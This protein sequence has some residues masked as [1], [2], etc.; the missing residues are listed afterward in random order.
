MF[1]EA[2]TK[3]EFPPNTPGHNW[4][5]DGVADYCFAGAGLV[6]TAG[7]GVAGDEV[8]AGD[9]GAGDEVGAGDTGAGDEVGVDDTGAGDEVG[10][11]DTGAGDT[12]AGD[13]V[14]VGDT[15]AGDEVGVGDTGAVPDVS[16]V[17]PARTFW[18]PWTITTSPR[19][20][21]DVMTYCS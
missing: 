6:G 5:S 9:T 16:T 3:T 7:V 13:E 4:C 20:K 2:T 14:G 21:P 17:I 12:G 10:V 15:G 8:G 18:V 11:G 1:S 19:F